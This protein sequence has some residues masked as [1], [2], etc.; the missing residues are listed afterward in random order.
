[1]LNKLKCFMGW[2]HY[3][4]RYIKLHEDMNCKRVALICDRCGKEQSDD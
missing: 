4:V 3:K 1:M 2:H